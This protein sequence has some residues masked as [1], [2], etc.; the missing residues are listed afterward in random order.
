M[1][2]NIPGITIVC[3]LSSSSKKVYDVK[4]MELDKK[5]KGGMVRRRTRPLFNGCGRS[6]RFNQM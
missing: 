3:S 2:K 6:S 4:S 5:S 1:S